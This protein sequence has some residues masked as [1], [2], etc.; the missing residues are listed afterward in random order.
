MISYYLDIAL[1]VLVLMLELFGAIGMMLIVQ[2][3]FYRVFKINLYKKFW[4]FLNKMD[5]KLTEMFG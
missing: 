5:K 1:C 4:K 2:L 3:I